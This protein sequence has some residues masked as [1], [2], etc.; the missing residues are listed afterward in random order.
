MVVDKLYFFDLDKTLI[1]CD[2]ISVWNQY[3]F[4]KKVVSDI[5]VIEQDQKFIADYKNACLDINAYYLFSMEL[6]S[7]L[8]DHERDSLLVEFY[9]T[10]IQHHFYKEA[11]AL[12]NNLLSR[13]E[14]IVIV[15][16]SPFFLVNTIAEQIGIRNVI[17]TDFTKKNGAYLIKGTPSFQEGKVIRVKE[18]LENSHIQYKKICFYSD[19]INDAPL[20]E[21]SDKAIAINPCTKLKELAK[22]NEWE[23]RN[24]V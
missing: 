15:S 14:V 8:S 17:A 22:E 23:I 24:W 12:I 21:F 20:L 4:G 6:I 19:S 16:A 9:E 10:V 7:S 3:L 11:L 2:S 13:N 1:S 5:S 18:W